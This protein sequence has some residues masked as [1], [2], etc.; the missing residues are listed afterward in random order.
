MFSLKIYYNII[1]KNGDV[2][3]IPKDIKE[4]LESL[5]YIKQGDVYKIYLARTKNKHISKEE[6]ELAKEI[7]EYALKL[8][9]KNLAKHKKEMELKK[10]EKNEK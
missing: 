8:H 3:S 10:L 9:D 2:M 7:S 4:E 1:K 5:N 6:R